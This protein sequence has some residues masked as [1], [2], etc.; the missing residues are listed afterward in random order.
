MKNR[1]MAGAALDCYDDEPN[2]HEFLFVMDNVVLTPHIGS[3]TRETRKRMGALVA[4]NI[5]AHFEGKE[6]LTPVKI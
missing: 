4:A 1:T 5:K 6:L 2:V 3:A